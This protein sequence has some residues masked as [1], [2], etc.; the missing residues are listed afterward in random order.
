[1]LGIGKAR[2]LPTVLLIDDDMVSR[3]VMATVLTMNG[4]TVHTSSNAAEA[5]SMLDSKTVIP[6]LILMDIQIPGMSGPELVRELRARSDSLLY[7]IS[8]SEIGPELRQQVDGFLLKPFGPDALE[9]LIDKDVPVARPVPPAGLD[10]IHP[11][12]LADFRGMMSEAAVKEIYAAV[13]ADLEQRYAALES[14]IERADRVEIRRIGHSIKGG[15]GMA[16][17][18]EAAH[19][20]EL[21]ESG[22]DDLEYSRSLLP[23]FQTAIGNLKRMLDAEFS[24]PN[25][26]SA[27]SS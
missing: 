13:A 10:A 21:L 15:C 2:R 24:Q 6:N 22:G 11:K 14:A 8:A 18:V 23:H 20:G 19:V 12:T 4:Y 26:N 27:A 5:L 16:G 9:Q 17:A 7:A 25:N 1:M 3:E